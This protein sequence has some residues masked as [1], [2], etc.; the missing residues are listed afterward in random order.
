VAALKDFDELT[1]AEADFIC[2]MPIPFDAPIPD[3]PIVFTS[4]NAVNFTAAGFADPEEIAVDIFC[5]EG[6][7]LEAVRNTFKAGRICAVAGDAASLAREIISLNAYPAV[8]FFCGNERREELPRLLW[9]AGI[10]V[11]E[12]I[13]YSTRPTP[14]FI[15][16]TPDAVLFF[17]PSAVVSFFSMNQLSA[18]AT[19]FAI[20]ATTAAAI[21]AKARSNRIITT[22]RPDQQSMLAAILNHFQLSSFDPFK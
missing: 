21:Q 13:V 8:T 19:C 7:T 5:L 16:D 3:T 15:K 9:E 6:A 17:S 11:R 18:T 4:S 12:V 10:E 22:T 20:G 1:F 14:R 2:P